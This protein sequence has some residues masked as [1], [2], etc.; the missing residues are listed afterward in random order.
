MKRKS[1]LAIGMIAV[2]LAALGRTADVKEGVDSFFEKRPAK[3]ASKVSTD[4]PAFF[5]WWEE[6][7][8]E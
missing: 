1:T 4:L 3:F 2:S 8:Y 7:E 5:P 6:R